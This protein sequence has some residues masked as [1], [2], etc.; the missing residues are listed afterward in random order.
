MRY[1][2]IDDFDG[3]TNVN[4]INMLKKEWMDY[5]QIKPMQVTFCSTLTDALTHLTEHHR[6]FDFILF[7]VDLNAKNSIMSDPEMV[8]RI[9]D[10]YFSFQIREHYDEMMVE[11]AGVLLYEY[12]DD[13][14]EISKSRMGFVSAYLKEDQRAKGASRGF[15]KLTD[16]FAKKGLNPPPH[17]HKPGTIAVDPMALLR[18]A[19]PKKQVSTTFQKE[20]VEPNCNPYTE[21]RSFTVGFSLILLEELEELLEK[22]ESQESKEK[23]LIQFVRIFKKDYFDGSKYPVDRYFQKILAQLID[24]PFFGGKSKEYLDHKIHDIL[25]ATFY[26]G[27]S[28]RLKPKDEDNIF[29]R[30]CYSTVKKVR[31]S[32]AHPTLL[33]ASDGGENALFL[34]CVFFRCV[35]DVNRLSKERKEK[36]LLLEKEYFGSPRPYEMNIASLMA[37]DLL[38]EHYKMQEKL[39]EMGKNK[40]IVFVDVWS[41]V[42]DKITLMETCQ[43]LEYIRFFAHCYFPL[44]QPN[45]V[46]VPEH[47]ERNTPLEQVTEEKIVMDNR[48]CTDFSS[49]KIPDLYLNY[50]CSKTIDGEYLEEELKKY[51]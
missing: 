4:S 13:V 43:Y 7:D 28:L 1:L 30:A 50:S 26:C 18:G 14:L 38:V 8:N 23:K 19:V 35:F 27:E 49:G 17:F 9:Y 48:F 15:H 25:L 24:M 2:W 36:Y 31:N 32:L 37:K 42:N 20:F 16:K 46:K 12:A 51:R 3:E 44:V 21:F 5:F 22:D 45:P 39:V 29:D 34:M 47:P 11:A 6:E 10:H 33:N 40:K 41:L